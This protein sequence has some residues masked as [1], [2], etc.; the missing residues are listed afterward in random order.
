M[1]ALVVYDAEARAAQ[2]PLPGMYG[3]HWPFHFWEGLHD[4]FR[5]TSLYSDAYAS[6]SELTRIVFADDAGVPAGVIP[7][8]IGG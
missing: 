1:A 2:K 6:T 7:N 5:P 8:T 4:L 3:A